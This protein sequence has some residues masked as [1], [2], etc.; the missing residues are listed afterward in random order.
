MRKRRAI[1]FSGNVAYG[2]DVAEA[3]LGRSRKSRIK[4]GLGSRFPFIMKGKES[5]GSLCP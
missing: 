1:D 5:N 3:S 4:T 2:L